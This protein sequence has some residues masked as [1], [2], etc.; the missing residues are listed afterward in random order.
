MIDCLVSYFGLDENERSGYRRCFCYYVCSGSGATPG[1]GVAMI[2]TLA[3]RDEAERCTYCRN[4]HTVVEGGPAAALTAAIRYLDAYH[5]PNHLR[6]VQSDVRGLPLP[7]S[8]FRRIEV[9]EE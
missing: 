6:K 8:S 5:E 3:V 4:F 9:R 1:A 7:L 2:T